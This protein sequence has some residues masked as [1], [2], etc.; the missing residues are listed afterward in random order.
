MHGVGRFM[1]NVLPHINKNR[2]NIILCVL[3]KKDVLSDLFISQN[4]RIRYLGKKKFDPSTF[5]SIYKI[6]K[7][8][9]IDLLHLHQYGSI[10]FGRIAGLIAGVPVIIHSHDTD[11][12]YTLYLKIFDLILAPFTDKV[13]AVSEGAKKSTINKKNICADKVIVMY[14]AVPQEK[15]DVLTPGEKEIEKKSLGIDPD[16]KIIGTVTRLR[17]EK[18]N[19]YFLKAASEVLKIFPKTKYIIV[20]DGP[21]CDE[22][23]QLCKKL[24]IEEKV[25]FYGFSSNVQKMYSLFD[26]TIIASVFEAFPYT[27]LEAIAMGKAVVSTDTDGPNEI[28]VNGETGFLVPVKDSKMLAKKIIYLLENDEEIERLGLNA[29]KLSGKYDINFYIRKLEEEYQN[30][31]SGG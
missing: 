8:E 19:E 15:Y 22:L 29:K 14:N 1:L 16:Y 9:K 30:L 13:I 28:L 6:I 31:L 17:V 23:Q 27:L 24:N 7:E 12:Y 3:R 4:I 5:L 25:I 18:G 2:F 21:L 10:N 11:P 20:G 26:I